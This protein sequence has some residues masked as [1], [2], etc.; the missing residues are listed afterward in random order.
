MRF[1][2]E[3]RNLDLQE[4]ILFY[5][6]PTLNELDSAYS[7]EGVCVC[8]CLGAGVLKI[9]FLAR[10]NFISCHASICIK[11]QAC[12]IGKMLVKYFGMF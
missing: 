1:L 5:R 12:E 2:L 3:A 11:N 8:V 4:W 7:I 9:L 6:V 10:L